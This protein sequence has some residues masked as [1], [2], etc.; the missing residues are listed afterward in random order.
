VDSEIGDRVTVN[1]Y[2]LIVGARVADGASVGP[3]AHLRPETKVGQ[4][5]KVGNFVELKKTTLGPGSKANHLSYLGDATIGADVNI[6]AGTITCNYDGEKKHETVIEDGAFIGSDTQLIA[7]VKVGKG[8]Y[9]GAG[10]S[11][12]QDVPAGALGIGRG[13]QSNVDG[14]V[15][16]KKGGG[17]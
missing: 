16:R 13:R 15:E 8:A 3:F 5:A 1:N 11:I 6:G 7:P 10:S 4:G 12:T 2:C 17:S 9:V 14:W